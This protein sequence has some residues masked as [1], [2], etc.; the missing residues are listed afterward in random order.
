MLEK[1]HRMAEEAAVRTSRRRFLGRVGR[2]AL[3]AAAALGGLLALAGDAQAATLCDATSDLQCRNQPP[4]SLCGTRERPGRC[5]GPP[6]CR[7][8]PRKGRGSQG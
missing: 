3:A 2:G 1:F 4:G 7:C 6:S 5:K 8:V